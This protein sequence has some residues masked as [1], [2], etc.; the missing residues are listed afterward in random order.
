M[1]IHKNPDSL[2]PHFEKNISFSGR[3]ISILSGSYLLHDAVRG[4]KKSWIEA[5][6]AGYLMYR[7]TSGYCP[8]KQLVR[9]GLDMVKPE[10]INIKTD[11]V[12]N[13]PRQEIYTFWRNLENLPLFMKHLKSVNTI[14]DTRSIWEA[15][16][17]ADMSK[18]VWNAIIV[19]D[20]PG[21]HIGWESVPD[22]DIYN[23]GSIKFLD[24][25]D[26]S[27]EIR[28]VISYQAPGGILGEGAGRLLSP[29]VEKMIREDIRNFK[30]FME[31]G[32]LINIEKSHKVQN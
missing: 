24:S 13:R 6:V 17:P 28:I 7:G 3:I 11:I 15:N 31:N 5:L 27:T 8:A 14:D 29:V 30:T 19:K 16:I 10:N 12:V 23:A 1:H 22:S 21:E 26:F 4:E 9:Q 32:T 20:I 2:I 18:L 25:S